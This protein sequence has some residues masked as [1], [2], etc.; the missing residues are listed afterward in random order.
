MVVVVRCGLSSAESSSPAHPAFHVRTRPHSSRTR[1]PQAHAL[2]SGHSPLLRR[3]VPGALLSSLV[4][5]HMG[6]QA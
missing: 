6:L 1:F 4:A 5:A 2:V 3:Y